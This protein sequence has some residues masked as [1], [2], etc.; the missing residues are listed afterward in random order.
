MGIVWIMKGMRRPRGRHAGLFAGLLI[1]LATGCGEEPVRDSSLVILMTNDTRGELWSCGCASRDYGGLGRRGTVV[2]SVRDTTSNL[3]VLETGGVFGL[4]LA[5]GPE[6]ADVALR[7]MRA[8]GYDAMNLGPA[9]F[10]FGTKFLAEK[11]EE[12]DFPFVTTNIVD[13]RTEGPFLGV[14]YRIRE[15]PDGLRVGILGVMDHEAS[16]PGY[17]D[18]EN[19]EVLP[20]LKAVRRYLPEV[21]GQADLVVL[22]SYLGLTKTQELL[23]QVDGLDVVLVGGGGNAFRSPKHR[24]GAV[25]FQAGNRGK[26]LGYVRLELEG[27]SRIV[28]DDG[29]MIPMAEGI[30]SDPAVAKVFLQAGFDPDEEGKNTH[31]SSSAGGGS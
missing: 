29:Y 9:D 8:M 17:S 14:P 30:P 31:T 13:Q 24:H 16:F 10:S 23:D 21:R 12:L 27:H 28:K 22:L 25:V 6:K 4:T 7:S 11:K 3:L 18:H 19:L 1:L 2:A 20:P 5:Y 15:L 26:Y